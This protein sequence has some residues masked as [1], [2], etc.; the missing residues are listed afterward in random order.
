MTTPI[1]FESRHPTAAKVLQDIYA[2]GAKVLH[3]GDMG[4]VVVVEQSGKQTWVSEVGVTV[5]YPTKEEMETARE[6]DMRERAYKLSVT[7]RIRRVRERG[8][9]REMI[10]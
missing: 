2:R 3:T 6:V 10:N 7:R 8:Y 9:R 5:H 1:R 4:Q